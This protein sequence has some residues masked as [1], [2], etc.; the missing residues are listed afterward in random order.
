MA[1]F[2]GKYIRFWKEKETN[3]DS[4]KKYK[5]LSPISAILT[6]KGISPIV[7][8]QNGG[9]ASLAW[10]LENRKTWDSAGILLPGEK[11]LSSQL[12]CVADKIYLCLFTSKEQ[13]AFNYI[14]V[15]LQKENYTEELDQLVRIELKRSSEKLVGHIVLQDKKN[16]YLLTLCK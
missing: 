13:R 7:V 10:A 15:P 4:V 16:A 5:F 9:T 6:S 3:L 11:I 14:T 8:M 12:V 2:N 1:V